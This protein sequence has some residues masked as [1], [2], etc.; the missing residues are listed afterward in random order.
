[1]KIFKILGLYGIGVLLISCMAAED[2]TE[3]ALGR[4][5]AS[6][7]FSIPPGA[8]DTLSFAVN[9]GGSISASVSQRGSREAAAESS[10]SVA[11]ALN[12]PQ[13]N[14]VIQSSGELASRVR[15]NYR[16]PRDMA[17]EGGMWQVALTNNS[18][19]TVSGTLKV[20]YPYDEY[21][22][23]GGS[24][25]TTSSQD[26]YSEPPPQDT[27]VSQDQ[28]Y[29]VEPQREPQPQETASDDT[30]SGGSSGGGT[31]YTPRRTILVNPRILTTMRTPQVISKSFVLNASD[32]RKVFSFN[33]NSPST[34]S[35]NAGLSKS[36]EN[37]AIILNGP[38]QQNAYARKDGN[39]PLYLSFTVTQDM[40][41]RGGQWSATVV[42]FYK[43]ESGSGG[44]FGRQISSMVGLDGKI[45]ITVN[46][47]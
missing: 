32:N 46:P 14:S 34:I 20:Y 2:L 10:G 41:Q 29:Q 24:G 4:Q 45:K 19:R 22:E 27:T 15:L 40:I 35:I 42:K 21:N 47:Q 18:D 37:F 11:L 9:K 36:N 28:G 3:S 23:S 25:R 1:M 7:S 16:V 30:T 6:K 13:G 33:V 26:T 5:Y 43:G 39:S 38:G 17:E 44:L 31:V 8:S 12:N